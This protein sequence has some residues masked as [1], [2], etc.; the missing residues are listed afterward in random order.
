MQE[1]VQQGELEGSP[2]EEEMVEEEGLPL[3]EKVM[4]I[5]WQQP[6]ALRFDSIPSP[7][8]LLPLHLW[9]DSVH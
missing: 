8:V 9:P 1:Q 7:E 3:N 4:Q 5:C 2:V 6:P